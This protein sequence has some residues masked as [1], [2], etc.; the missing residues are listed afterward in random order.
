MAT[1]AMSVDEA[2]L[3]RIAG[4]AA[5]LRGRRHLQR[6]EVVSCH[7]HAK[8]GRAFG[9]VSEDGKTSTAIV[10]VLNECG[11]GIS[12]IHATC[13]CGGR[14]C[15]SHAVALLLHVWESA[16]TGTGVPAARTPAWE[17][18]LA[19]LAQAGPPDGEGHRPEIG[20]Q[21]ELHLP[22]AGDGTASGA[23]VSLR[24]VTTGRSGNWVRTG[25]SWSH[26]SYQ[27][28]I[29]SRTAARHLSLLR[30]ILALEAG[31]SSGYYGYHPQ[32]I[33]LDD[34]P[35][36]RIWDLL[37]EARDLGLPL[38]H[39]GRHAR[40]VTVRDEPARLALDVARSDEG[41]I[42]APRMIVGD[43]PVPLDAA[44]LLGDPPHGLAWWRQDGG[45]GATPGDRLLRLA[46]LDG[47][48]TETARLVTQ[49]SLVIPRD[50]EDRFLLEYYPRLRRRVRLVPV[51][52]AVAL[53][54]PR[55]P[56]LELTARRRPG[57]RVDVRWQ[58]VHVLGAA[59]HREDLRSDPHGRADRDAR[60]ERALESGVADLVAD[61]CPTLVEATPDG[62]R[63]VER[64]LLEG[65]PVIR[66]LDEVVPALDGHDGVEVTL[67]VDGDVPEYREA[68]DAPLVTVSGSRADGQRDWF[69]LA[70][71]VSVD[72]QEVPFDELFTALAHGQQHLLLPSG[73]Y[74]TL[75]RPE[76]RQLADLIEEARALQDAPSG[77]MR[78]SRFQAGMWQELERLADVDGQART[79]AESVRVLTRAAESVEHPVPRG[80]RATLR[81]YQQSG[82][83]WLAALH[84]YGLG[85]ILADDMGLGKTVQALSL[86]CHVRER[87]GA[88]GSPFLVVCPTSVVGNWASEAARFAPDLAVVAVKETRARR[89]AALGDAVAGADLVVTSYTLFRLE[90]DDYA[91]LPWAGLVLDEAQ[92]VKNHQSQGYRCAR[93][94]PAPFK[95]AITGTP[96][97]NNLMELWSLLSIT[98][99]GLFASPAR[100]TQ[101]YRTP[102]ERDGDQERLARLRRR[103]APLMLRR[104]KD[105]VAADL[106]PK[107]E[108][109]VE[110]DLNPRHRRVYQTYLQRERQK[111]LGLLGDVT[112]NRFEIFRSLTLLRQVS[113]DASLV[114][115]AH[116]RV[117][118]TKLDALMEQVRDIVAEGHRTLVFSQFTRFLDA[119][120]QRLRAEDIDHCYLD[121]STRDRAAV[122]REFKEGTAPA[123]LISLK[124]GGFG[125]NLAEADYCI[126]LDPWWNPATEAQAVDRVHRIGQVKP[127]VVY[128][129]VARDTIEE[130]VMALKAAKAELFANV[131]EGGAFE[132]AS[133]G[134]E[135]IRGLL[136]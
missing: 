16:A 61:S 136:E 103:V 90:Y 129:L 25:V 86:A 93:R 48:D 117:P 33:H 59:R 55:P 5:F 36:R 87:S 47:V 63:L 81:P 67:V 71:S 64:A 80:L 42:L 4:Q 43:T 7:W 97:E 89:G 126:L 12:S 31:T 22:A 130:K 72:G 11:R 29:A 60:A 32:V 68:H 132:S 101:Y 6:G 98:A 94:L 106:P 95:L 79:W 9:E 102:I 113:L 65:M 20:L 108:Q 78:L 116:A 26:L 133:L 128:R 109:V 122:L 70:V 110:L 40:P 10:V 120:R 37:A 127:V 92:F 100:F 19:P 15:C 76:L 134:P 18:T 3:H 96:M 123:F 88:G 8:G 58:W 50:D 13:T 24:P 85:G 121:G 99:P 111:V 114:D 115:P 69:D 56:V 74:F 2:V 34:F 82:F 84:G 73:T 41:L 131:M 1:V 39:V 53:P 77:Q 62:P 35:S 23:R 75:D 105:Q 30:E 124:A 119:A 17:R 66:F 54:E 46:R 28:Y 49:G 52:E 44:V 57:H 112:K 135:D 51:D 45:S 14:P 83:A 91:A 104:T 38:V 21:F 107:Q 27:R 118:S 125:V